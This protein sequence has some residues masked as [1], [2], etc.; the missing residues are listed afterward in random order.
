MAV[1]VC[2][3]FAV[4]GDECPGC[5]SHLHRVRRGG[6]QGAD[7]WWYCDEECIAD[8]QEW[9][10]KKH[11][12]GHYATRDLLCA[13]EICSARGL[14]SQAMLDEYADYVASIKGTSLDPEAGAA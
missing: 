9:L 1:I 11:T 10:A 12:E 3:Q 4:L 14:P 8:H 5:G 7:G 2:G 13:C 6:F